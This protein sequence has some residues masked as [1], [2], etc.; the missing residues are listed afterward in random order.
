M[1]SLEDPTGLLT[2]WDT[3]SVQSLP[4]T[5]PFLSPGEGPYP[6]LRDIMAAVSSCTTSITVLTAEI[7]G[8][9]ADVSS[10][11]HD[12]QKL[13]ERTSAMEGRVSTVKDDMEP[14]M[15]DEKQNVMI[16]AQYTTCLEVLEKRMRRYNVREISIP[17][18]A[19]GKNHIAFIES[20]LLTVFSKESFIPMFSVERAHR[21][22]MRSLPPGHLPLTFL[23]KMLNNKDRDVTLAKARSMSGA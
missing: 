19:E 10:I 8:V 4:I 12:L 9:K 14:L 18:R 15:R 22:P 5:A 3:V 21:V 13:R 6:T 7:K 11:R 16:T 1:V 20:W 17:E 23:F 2:E